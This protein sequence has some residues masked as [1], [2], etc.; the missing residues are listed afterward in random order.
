MQRYDLVVAK[1][2]NLVNQVFRNTETLR[3]V[4]GKV[5]DVGR[6]GRR[7]RAGRLLHR[8]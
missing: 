4:S 6:R 8:R 7:R 5:D 1:D 3:T 2:A